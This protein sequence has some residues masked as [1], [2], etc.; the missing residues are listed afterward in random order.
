MEVCDQEYSAKLLGFKGI[1]HEAHDTRSKV[2]W[3]HDFEERVIGFVV[4]Q[5]TDT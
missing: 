3:L 2:R 5:F 1:M 4:F